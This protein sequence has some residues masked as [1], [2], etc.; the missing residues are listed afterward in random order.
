MSNYIPKSPLTPLLAA[1]FVFLILFALFARDGAASTGPAKIAQQQAIPCVFDNFVWFKDQE[2]INEIRND[3]PSFDGTAPETGDSIN[4]ILGALE[5]M[6]KKK[7]LPK[8][9]EYVFFSGG[10]YQYRPEHIFA[11]RDAKIPVCKVVFQNSPPQIEKELAQATQSLVNKDY[12]KVITRSFVEGAVVQVYRKYG[13]LRAA[14]RI[15][16]A[17]LD[18]SC[19]NSVVVKVAAEPG[20][21]YAWERAVWSGNQAL[22][23]QSLDAAIELKP[24]DLADGP[25]I[26]AGLQAAV[27]VYRKLGYVESQIA[28]K[29]VFDDIKRRIALNVAITE[30]PQFRMGNFIVKGIPDDGVQLL[31]GRWALKSGAIYDA[32]YIDDFIKKLVDD[33]LILP[34]LVRL[35]KPEFKLDRQK[36]TVDV[37]IDFKV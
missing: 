5:R 25:K 11:A 36:L 3:L 24:G 18:Q 13:Y 23:S 9:V 20:I 22:S 8:E 37:I 34:D 33:K 35:L 31:K 10:G 27:I 17:E 1:S 14:A 16:S 19:R 32:T 29:P 26:D 21:A 28:P 30:G 7:G 2:I 15:V 12:S 6:L 4:K